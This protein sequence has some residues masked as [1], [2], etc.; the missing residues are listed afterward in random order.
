MLTKPNTA[1]YRRVYRCIYWFRRFVTKTDTYWSVS[2]ASCRHCTFAWADYRVD[3][4]TQLRTQTAPALQIVNNCKAECT[5]SAVCCYVRR[6]VLSDN[7]QPRESR[8]VSRRNATLVSAHLPRIGLMKQ[9][10]GENQLKI[11]RPYAENHNT[12]SV[13]FTERRYASAVWPCVCPSV[14]LSR[15]TF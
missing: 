15:P 13:I 9:S 7:M 5:S 3:G 8:S 11:Y 4:R 10:T 14:C 1:T 12:W 6:I 2:T